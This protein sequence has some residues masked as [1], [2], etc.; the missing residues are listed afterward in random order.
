MENVN[1]TYD[2]RTQQRPQL[3]KFHVLR[4]NLSLEFLFRITGD[5][6]AVIT[7]L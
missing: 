5:P 7:Y 4:D 1:F 6:A 2:K 3:V